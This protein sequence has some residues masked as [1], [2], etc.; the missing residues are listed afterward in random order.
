[1]GLQRATKLPASRPSSVAS[2]ADCQQVA[3]DQEAVL[4]EGDEV[5]VVMEADVRSSELEH[6]ELQD[7]QLIGVG[8]RLL[9]ER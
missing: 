3:A 2:A 5:A 8:A 4:D 6:E 9:V 7:A 1:M